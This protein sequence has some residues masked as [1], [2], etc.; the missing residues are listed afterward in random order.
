MRWAL[1]GLCFALAVGLAIT[2]AAL[3]ADNA[4]CRHRVDAVERDVW[5]RLVEYKRLS[6]ER[7]AEATP[8]RLAAAHWLHLRSEQGRREALAR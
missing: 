7:L 4:R 3:R 5:D 2:T 8:E 1:A 6:V